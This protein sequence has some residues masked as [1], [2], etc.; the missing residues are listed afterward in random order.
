VFIGIDEK[1]TVVLSKTHSRM[2]A[3]A[4]LLAAI[5]LAEPV[6]I[7]IDEKLTVVLSKT[8]GLESLEVQGTMSMVVGS[9]ADAYVAAQV[10]GGQLRSIVEVCAVLLAHLLGSGA[11]A[12][13]GA[14]VQGGWQRHSRLCAV[15]LAP[16]ASQNSCGEFVVLC[17][18]YTWWH[19]C[20]RQ[21]AQHALQQAVLLAGNHGVNF[22]MTCV[23]SGV[24]LWGARVSDGCWTYSHCRRYMCVRA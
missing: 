17:V 21:M 10:R 22:C 16:V 13:L 24:S 5:C 20:W 18:C 8:G 1:L 23:R 11:G 4:T 15:L 9:D 2:P 14:Q 6:F 7:G 19:R 12:Y 3:A